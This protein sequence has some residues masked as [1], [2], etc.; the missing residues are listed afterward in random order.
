MVRCKRMDRY[1]MAQA[2]AQ[3]QAYTQFRAHSLW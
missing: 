2:Q 1:A 3:A